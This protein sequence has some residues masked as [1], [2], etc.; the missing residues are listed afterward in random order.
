MKNAFRKSIFMAAIV[1]LI[2]IMS[3]CGEEA[4]ANTVNSLDD[5]SGKKIGVQRKTTGD[6]YA[7]DIEDAEVVRFNRGID[8]V[9][10]LKKGVIDAVIIDDEPAKVFV[11]EV[12]GLTLLD[13]PFAEE[14]YGIAVSKDNPEL[15]K[16]INTALEK[17]EKDGTL[18]HI[19]DCLLYTSPSP[20]DI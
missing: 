19:K 14:E 9:T 15:L 6:I 4:V 1:C 13:E 12:N 2:M 20:R 11:E 3:G 5:L 18:A 10:A 7:S 8:A 17:L 16:D